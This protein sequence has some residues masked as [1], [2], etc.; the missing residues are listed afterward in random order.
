METILQI[1][2]D[3]AV[4]PECSGNELAQFV[5]NELERRGY[6]IIATEFQKDVSAYYDALKPNRYLME[7]RKLFSGYET[8]IVE[9]ET[10]EEALSKARDRLKNDVHFWDSHYEIGSLKCVKKLN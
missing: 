7:I 4:G 6:V 5:A 2:L 3:I 8:F 9:A 10:K 1:S